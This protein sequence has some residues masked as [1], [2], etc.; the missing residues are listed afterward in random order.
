MGQG[1]AQRARIIP[2]PALRG[3]DGAHALRLDQDGRRDSHQ[4]REI[5]SANFSSGTLVSC[6]RKLALATALRPRAVEVSSFGVV[7]K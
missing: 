1:L 2:R 6:D 5:L 3:R 4:C 7:E